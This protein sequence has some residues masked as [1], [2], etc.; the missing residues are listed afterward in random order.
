MGQHETAGQLPSQREFK[1]TYNET[2][3]LKALA[4]LE[5][6]VRESAWP[7]DGAVKAAAEFL[8]SLK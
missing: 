2:V 3:L 5:A 4:H 7:N 1:L 8:E 6:V